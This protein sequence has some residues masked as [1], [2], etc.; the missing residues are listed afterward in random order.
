MRS[1]D[2][3]RKAVNSLA[4]ANN[5]FSAAV[6]QLSNSIS[7]LNVASRN[8]LSSATG[9]SQDSI[10]WVADLLNITV[11]DL[12]NFFSLNDRFPNDAD[13]VDYFG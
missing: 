8:A 1:Q 9:I 12:Y 2:N 6:S 10:Q 7:A 11:Y 13:V 3:L 5:N 4:H